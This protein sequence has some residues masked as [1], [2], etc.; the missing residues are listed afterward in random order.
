MKGPQ[1]N[2]EAHPTIQYELT[3]VLGCHR[4]L[5]HEVSVLENTMQTA[6]S[7]LR[8]E[9]AAITKNELIQSSRCCS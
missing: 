1:T 8:K 2:S 6:T 7:K 9:G 3:L 4:T 5:W